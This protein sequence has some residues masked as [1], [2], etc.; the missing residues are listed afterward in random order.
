MCLFESF[1]IQGRITSSAGAFPFL[2][3]MFG[4]VFK[5]SREQGRV[6]GFLCMNPECHRIPECLPFQF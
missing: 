4:T 5:V 6:N 1:T 2:Y 3:C